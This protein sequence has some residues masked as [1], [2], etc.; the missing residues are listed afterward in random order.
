V[1]SCQKLTKSLTKT[2]M[3]EVKARSKKGISGVIGA[4]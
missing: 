3:H 4:F 1:S 2:D